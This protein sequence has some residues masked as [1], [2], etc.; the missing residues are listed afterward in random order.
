MSVFFILLIVAIAVG[1]FFY[2]RGKAAA[3]PQLPSQVDSDAALQAKSAQAALPTRQKPKSEKKLA[4]ATAELGVP[5]EGMAE[6][7][8]TAEAQPTPAELEQSTAAARRDA[9][10]EPLAKAPRDVEGLRRGLDKSRR[11]EGFFGRLAALLRGKKE[12]SADIAGQ[13][14]DVLLTSDV[15]VQTTQAIVEKIR[16]SLSRQELTNPDVVWD[17]LRVEARRILNANA[18]S[19]ALALRTRPS[20]IL[21][22][23]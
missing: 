5:A 12:L 6:P 15:G 14:E 2:F 16:E 3:T 4:Q 1:A 9:V 23:V 17:A 22:L 11:P 18:Q 20:V 19:T 10:Q 7:A 21:W 8:S 13:I